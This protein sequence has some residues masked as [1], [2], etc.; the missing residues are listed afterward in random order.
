MRPFGVEFGSE[1]IERTLLSAA[2]GAGR[3]NGGSLERFMHAFMSSVLLG[4]AGRIR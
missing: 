3:P 2:V 4:L 1:G